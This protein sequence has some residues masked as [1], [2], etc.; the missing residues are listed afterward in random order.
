MKKDEK[1]GYVRYDSRLD[2]F[3]NL[4]VT[5]TEK[6]LPGAPIGN[7]HW[8]RQEREYI[9]DQVS[10]SLPTLEDLGVCLTHMENQVPWELKPHTF[11]IYHDRHLEEFGAR[12]E[13]PN[14]V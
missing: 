6:C 11:G 3:F 9:T 10:N 1:W 12:A 8:E 7:L 4:K 13:P 5:L 14:A 2:P